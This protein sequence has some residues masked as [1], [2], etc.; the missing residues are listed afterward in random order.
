MLASVSQLGSNPRNAARE[1]IM[2][3]RRSSDGKLTRRRLVAGAAAGAVALATEPAS[4]QRCPAS[5]ARAKG[6][7]VWLDMD[8]QELD[9]AYDQSVYAFNQRNIAER[10][11]VN[12]ERVRAILGEPQI[13]AYGGGPV[14]KEEIYKNKPPPPPVLVFLPGGARA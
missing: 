6:P 8:Q 9:D 4:A 10:R 2:R 5:P 7:L 3:E 1:E 12:S 14:R 11:L 13:I